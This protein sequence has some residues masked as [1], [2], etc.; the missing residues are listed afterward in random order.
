MKMELQR[1]MVRTGSTALV[2]ATCFGLAA[3]VQ[4]DTK[5]T[6]NDIPVNILFDESH[7][8]KSVDPSTGVNISKSADQRIVWQSVDASGK[9]I[10]EDYKIYFDPFKNGHLRSNSQGTRKSP[11][12]ADDAPTGVEYKYTIEGQ[13]CKSEPLDPRFFL[14]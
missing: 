9:H 11:K 13:K 14:T 3:C 10:K 8:P 7:C 5:V 1:F 6:A 2:A 4:Q 12:I